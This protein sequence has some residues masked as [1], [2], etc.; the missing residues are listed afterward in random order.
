MSYTTKFRKIGA[1]ITVFMLIMAI[2]PVSIKAEE[3]PVDAA[4]A[5]VTAP[6]VALTTEVTIEENAPVESPADEVV[7]PEASE[8]TVE[9]KTE[10]TLT[11]DE[12]KVDAEAESVKSASLSDIVVLPTTREISFQIDVVVNNTYGGTATADGVQIHALAG[13]GLNKKP[14]ELCFYERGNDITTCDGMVPFPSEDGYFFFKK[15]FTANEDPATNDFSLLV[16]P[17]TF[18]GKGFSYTMT[19]GGVCDN[20][21]L[22]NE[23]NPTGN[24]F[25]A[26]AGAHNCTFEFNQVTPPSDKFETHTFNLDTVIEGP[27][28]AAND[29]QFDEMFYVLRSGGNGFYVNSFPDNE[30]S[31]GAYTATQLR[32]IKMDEGGF[33]TQKFG[34]WDAGTFYIDLDSA[35]KE[36]AEKYGYTITT[37]GVCDDATLWANDSLP[38]NFEENQIMSLPGAMDPRNHDCRFVFSNEGTDGY[39][40]LHLDPTLINNNEGTST[41][42]NFNLAVISEQPLMID[43][44]VGEATRF[45][46][47]ADQASELSRIKA[48][49]FTVITV[50]G[51]VEQ[52]NGYVVSYG[53]CSGDLNDSNELQNCTIT[54]DDPVTEG[55]DGYNTI[56]VHAVLINDGTGTS[57][58]SDFQIGIIPAPLNEGDTVYPLKVNGVINESSDTRYEFTAN[59]AESVTN[60]EGKEFV[61]VTVYGNAE[62]N[63]NY[64]ISYSAGCST[65][66]ND[67]H[68]A[69]CTITFNDPGQG[70]GGD[71]CDEQP[72][73]L[74]SV[75][76]DPCN[77][78]GRVIVTP[79]LFND[80]GGTSTLADFEITVSTEGSLLINGEGQEGSSYTFSADQ[81]AEQD[82]ES[83]GVTTVTAARKEGNNNP[84][85]IGYANCEGDLDDQTELTSC[86]VVFNDTA[87][88]V[89]T[90][91]T[92]T[93]TN[94]SGGS[95]RSGG[96]RR[97]GFNSGEVLGAFTSADASTDTIPGACVPYL[98]KY[99]YRG[100]NNDPEQVMK[101]QQFLNSFNG[102]GLPVTG[103]FGVLTE[104][105]VNNLQAKYASSILKPWVDAGLMNP[106][107]PTGMVYKTTLAFINSA[108][109]G[110]TAMT[111]PPLK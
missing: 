51:N 38:H 66:I 43:G 48:K 111:Y 91:N 32:V 56:R 88:T 22:K 29:L 74:T 99:M 49:A 104:Q 101:L 30:G 79:Q 3:T 106:E 82:I 42:A 58:L 55:T 105:A 20:E 17:K 28:G 100:A 98:T 90:G 83:V 78:Y 2:S 33:V 13:D 80:N 93:N 96:T 6:E 65:I 53:V 95:S 35:T 109:C 108:K 63:R 24:A 103:F 26:G 86:S 107:A 4:P 52:N 14:I 72:T 61:V 1:A 67:G 37:E 34:N 12:V 64:A 19:K 85:D 45:D 47:T 41:L 16:D 44:I 39:A 60:V 21:I 11:A 81:F 40:R 31:D 46:F 92:G 15:T 84:Y 73:L 18:D 9:E 10:E 27:E 69:D 87:Q 25:Y 23:S 110:G 77:G 76:V 62:M 75:I 97:A 8:P 5:E 71:G 7:A 50:L 57:T 70:G 36:R 94:S 102:A 68:A 59:Q 54:F 89:D